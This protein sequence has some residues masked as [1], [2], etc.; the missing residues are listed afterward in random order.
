M[1]RDTLTTPHDDDN[2]TAG[3]LLR[4]LRSRLTRD[5]IT[6]TE[7]DLEAE[8]LA[9]GFDSYD[10]S[11]LWESMTLGALPMTVRDVTAEGWSYIETAY[12]VDGRVIP[13]RVNVEEWEDEP[14]V[15][16]YD[17]R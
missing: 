10:V 11:L 17:M 2:A 8:H 3:D 5:L 1:Q 4:A 13:S 9:W 14:K 15:D 7:A 12:H 16:P 6:R